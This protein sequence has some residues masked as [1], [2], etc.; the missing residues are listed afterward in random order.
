M[1]LAAAQ[2]PLFLVCPDRPLTRIA[3]HLDHRASG[4]TLNL[5]SNNPFR[6]RAISP[7]LPSPFDD[8]PPRP[9]SRNPFLDPAIATRA[10]LQNIRSSADT[11]ASTDN[12]ASPTADDLFVRAES[13]RAEHCFLSTW[14]HD[15]AAFAFVIER[16]LTSG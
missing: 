5:S 6:N 15:V 7:A 9:V 12:K 2:N 1:H 11:M 16:V 14:A 10:S 3:V 8:P 4:L 13:L